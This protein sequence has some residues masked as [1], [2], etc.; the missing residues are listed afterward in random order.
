MAKNITLICHS[1]K[2]EFESPKKEYN[3]KI[4]KGQK[5]FF[6][7]RGCVNRFLPEVARNNKFKV[8]N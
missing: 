7:G 8:F 5:R 3:Q 2:C 4:K 6:C 1:C